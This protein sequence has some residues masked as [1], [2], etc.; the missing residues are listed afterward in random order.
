MLE[1]TMRWG[2]PLALVTTYV[3]MVDSRGPNPSAMIQQLLD[4]LRDALTGLIPKFF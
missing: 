4:S 1:W 3:V 2:V